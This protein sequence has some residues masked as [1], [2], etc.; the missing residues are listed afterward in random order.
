[1]ARRFDFHM[2]ARPSFQ[3]TKDRRGI[4]QISRGRSQRLRDRRNLC[5]LLLRQPSSINPSDLEPQ[6]MNGRIIECIADA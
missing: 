6:F 5:G 2:R 4:Q 1:M 3:P